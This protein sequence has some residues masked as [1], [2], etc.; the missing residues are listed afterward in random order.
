MP[1]HNSILEFYGQ[2]LGLH[3]RVSALTC[4]V[5]WDLVEK[6]SSEL[7]P[8]TALTEASAA[9]DLAFNMRE[10][11]EELDEPQEPATDHV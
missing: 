7:H 4:T 10:D 6:A 1:P 9:S 2:F 8:M 11:Q 3:D 5:M